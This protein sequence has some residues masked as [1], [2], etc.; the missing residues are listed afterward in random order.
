MAAFKAVGNLPSN[1]TLYD[2]PA[3]KDATNEYFNDAPVGQ[4]FVA[5]ATSLKPV[6]L[7]AKNQP[8][9]D[10]VEN[11]LRSV[12]NGQRSAGRR[13]VRGGHR[14]ATKAAEA[15]SLVTT[16]TGCTCLRRHRRRGPATRWPPVAAPRRDG[17]V[18]AV[19]VRLAVLPASSRSSGCS[20][21]V[22]TVLGLAARL[23]P[24]R[25]Q[26]GLGRASTTTAS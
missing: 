6:Y 7:G 12:E 20:R 2:E 24:A 25:R 4:L 21:C 3:L 23:E 18:H 22:Y 8:V 9:R 5:G 19:R 13:L 11:A 10:A 17:A 26:P 15:E 1:P 16:T 14:P